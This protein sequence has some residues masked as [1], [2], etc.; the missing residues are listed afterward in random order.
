MVNVFLEIERLKA[1][2]QGRGHNTNTIDLIVRKAEREIADALAQHMSGAMDSA[3]QTGVQKDSADFINEL[4][5]R[6]GAFIL[7]TE[8]GNTDFSTPPFPML[9]HLLAHGAKPMK[10][11]SGVYKVVPVGA[12]TQKPKALIHTNIF[13][14][15]KA[16]SADRYQQALNNYKS[17]IPKGSKATEFRTATSKQSRNTSWV[18]PAKEKDF[19]E[20]LK[21]INDS[22]SGSHDD[23]VMDVIRKYEEGQ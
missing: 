18:L 23:I 13:D 5:P 8:S 20:D 2:L 14:A 16:I 15:Q 6:P 12:N 21:N 9:D 10:D 22:L 11:G 4:R 7:E 1:T 17:V 19:T 3:I